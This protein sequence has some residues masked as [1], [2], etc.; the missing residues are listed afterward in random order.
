MGE[1]RDVHRVVDRRRDRVALAGDQ[2]RRDGA[3]SPGSTARMRSSIASRMPSI[4]GGVA[5]PQRRR[6][7][8]GFD[9][10]DARRAQSR[11]RRCPGNTYRARSRSR[12]AAAAASGGD[13]RALNVNEAADRRRGALAHRDAH[14]LG[15]LRRSGRLRAVDAHDDAVGA[16]ALLAH[17]DKARERDACRSD[18]QDRM[19]DPRGL[20]ASRRRSPA[21]MPANAKRERESR[22]A[23]GA[24]ERQSPSRRSRAAER[25]PQRRLAIGGEIKR[26]CRS[27]TRPAARAAAGRARS[28]R[29]P[30]A[31]AAAQRLGG[32]GN[33]IR[34]RQPQ[35]PRRRRRRPGLAPRSRLRP[36]PAPRAMRLADASTRP[37]DLRNRG[38]SL[39]ATV[40]DSARSRIYG[41]SV[42]SNV[43]SGVAISTSSLGRPPW[44]MC[45]AS[46]R[47]D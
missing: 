37:H 13:R 46:R 22:S 29:A 30:I 27:R 36:C 41:A 14:A 5:Q 16:L 40:R 38:R 26:R 35:R 19:R 1:A 47:C 8:G 33:A 4:D 12:R 15:R 32:A 25:R 20:A 34:Q 45:R 28:R 6:T 2:R 39:R 44:R 10:L 23:A 9:R 18:S 43:R 42:S 31:T 3:L 7:A 11:R 21:A 17:L 24:P